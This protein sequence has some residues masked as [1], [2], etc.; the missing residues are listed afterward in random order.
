VSVLGHARA[1]LA[2]ALVAAP[3]LLVMATLRLWWAP[4]LHTQHPQLSLALVQQAATLLFGSAWSDTWPA[5]LLGGLTPLALLGGLRRSARPWLLRYGWLVPT[6]VA[7]ALVAWIN[8][9]GTQPVILFGGNVLRLMIYALPLLLGFALFA[10]DRVLPHVTPPP[11]PRTW[12]PRVRVALGALLML[13]LG[14]PFVALDRYQRVEFRP[15][16]DGP[17]VLAL[18]HESLRAAAAL[19]AGQEVRFDTSQPGYVPGAPE[20][21]ETQRVHWFLWRGWQPAQGAVQMS[22][23]EAV[24]LLPS[25]DAGARVLELRL[26]G[27]PGLAL[28]VAVN[29]T[30]AGVLVLAQAP[31]DHTLTIPAGVLFRGDNLV[32]LTR[33][34]GGVAPILERVVVRPAA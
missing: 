31:S 9:P 13:V 29:G 34:D 30:P 3:P 22:A 8:I 10:L 11:P 6:T 18:T 21:Y 12:S 20:S 4:G 26:G 5:L 33:A 24:L 7:L 1:L 14:F 23:S 25:F 27:A 17:L 28:Q 15:V 19:Q 32:T 2:M 16:R